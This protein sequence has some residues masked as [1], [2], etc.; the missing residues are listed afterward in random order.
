EAFDPF[1]NVAQIFIQGMRLPIA[2]PDPETS[3]R[4]AFR[5]KTE[6]RFA[7]E[8]IKKGFVQRVRVGVD[9]QLRDS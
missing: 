8:G 4:A 1:W 2:A 9:D 6:S 5:G 7:A 3:V